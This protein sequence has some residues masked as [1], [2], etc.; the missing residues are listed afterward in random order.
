MIILVV[1]YN[2]LSFVFGASNYIHFIMA[3]PCDM[4][5]SNDARCVVCE[6]LYRTV[7]FSRSCS[8]FFIS[9]NE[10]K[11]FFCFSRFLI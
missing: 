10:K 8:F 3:G 9:D 2:E 1:L 7:F 11:N 5:L 4:C 6:F